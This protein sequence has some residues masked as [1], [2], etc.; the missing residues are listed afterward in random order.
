MPDEISTFLL[1]YRAFISTT[2][3]GAIWIA[4]YP[5]HPFRFNKLSMAWYL[6]SNSYAENLRRESKDQQAIKLRCSNFKS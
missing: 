3:L 1:C 2:E 6:N 4:L 5:C